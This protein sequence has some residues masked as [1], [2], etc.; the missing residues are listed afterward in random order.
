MTRLETICFHLSYYHTG[1]IVNGYCGYC[2]ITAVLTTT[3]NSCTQ[4]DRVNNATTVLLVTSVVSN[5]V[6][7]LLLQLVR[8]VPAF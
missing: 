6:D 4:H 7:V 8:A 2:T 1:Y 5:Q 3:G